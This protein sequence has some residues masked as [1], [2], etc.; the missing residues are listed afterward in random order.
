MK[1]SKETIEI[2]KNFSAINP[3]ITFKKGN[4]QKTISVSAHIF[5]S[6]IVPDSFEKDFSIFSIPEFLSVLSIF[7]DPDIK[8]EDK[9]FTISDGVNTVKY[10]YTAPDLIKSPPE[11]NITFPKADV[12]FTLTKE[13][14]S[15]ILEASKTLN[16]EYLFVTEKGLIVKSFTRSDNSESNQFTVAVD[17]VTELEKFEYVIKIENMKVVP[18][19][20][21]VEVSNKCFHF[22][23]KDDN[24]IKELN[25]AIAVESLG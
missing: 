19:E 22:V 18:A 4:V 16:L 25:Y 6:A 3:G 17:Y 24:N 1:L 9:F 2:I 10:L 11:K 21:D 8:C 23:A 7:K 13:K 20:Y 15:K 14:L 5:A 12:T